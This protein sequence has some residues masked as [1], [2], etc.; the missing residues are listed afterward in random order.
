MTDKKILPAALLCF[1]FG[2]F[3]AHRFY[4]GHT[5][6]ATAI[7]ILMLVSVPLMLVFLGFF[8]ILIPTIWVFIDLFLI[9]GLVAE[10]NNALAARMR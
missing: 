8:T 4:T 5:G 2:I 7:L 9:P 10:H 6:S 3:G 1:F